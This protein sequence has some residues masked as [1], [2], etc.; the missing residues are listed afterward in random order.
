M[1][2]RSLFSL[3]DFELIGMLANISEMLTQ[4]QYDFWIAMEHNLIIDRR[5][6]Q[7]ERKQVIYLLRESNQ[8]AAIN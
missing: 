8:C 4:P 5:L 1:S 6:S 3:P 7:D 2:N